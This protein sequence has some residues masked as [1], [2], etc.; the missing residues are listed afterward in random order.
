MIWILRASGVDLDFSS[1]GPDGGDDFGCL[2]FYDLD[3]MR[4]GGGS[5]VCKGHCFRIIVNEF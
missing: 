3:F 2:E 4:F 1:G 5:E